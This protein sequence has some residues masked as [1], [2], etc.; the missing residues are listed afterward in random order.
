MI[1]IPCIFAVLNLSFACVKGNQ[2]WSLNLVSGL[3]NVGAAAWVY[4][5]GV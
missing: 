2:A 4:G 3:T 5:L 1:V